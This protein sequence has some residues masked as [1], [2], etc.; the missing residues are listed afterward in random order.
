[1]S[2]FLEWYCMGL[3][4]VGIWVY[5]EY[6]KIGV[7]FTMGE[8]FPYLM[9]AVLGPVIFLIIGV[10]YC[11]YIMEHL[12]YKGQPFNKIV[13]IPGKKEKAEEQT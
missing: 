10:L 9:T 3:I 6:Y 4:G 12:S 7:D 11:P 1:M 2:A 5:L 8:L 13:L